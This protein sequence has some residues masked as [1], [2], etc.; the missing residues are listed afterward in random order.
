M[1]FDEHRPTLGLIMLD[2]NFPR[3]PGD[4]GN[5]DTFDFEVVY[6]RVQGATP[7][8]VVQAN[9]PALLTPFLDAARTLEE[10]GARMISTSCGFLAVFHKQIQAAVKIPV[11]SSSLL[12]I[13]TAKNLVRPENKVGVI[14]VSADSLSVRHF[15]GVGID[16]NDVLVAGM[17]S[18]S[19]FVSVFIHDKKVLDENLC[20]QEIVAVA[21]DFVRKNPE[22]GALVLECTNMP[23][24]AAAIR[25]A[26]GLPVFDIVTLLNYGSSLLASE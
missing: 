15:A 20:R 21:S 10:K 26:T 17:P 8:R 23:P 6:E 25:D 18:R 19:E 24:Y 16:R 9:D 13:H 7:A 3:I 1:N 14:T 4:V 22:I 5:P 2:T 11:F 12:Q